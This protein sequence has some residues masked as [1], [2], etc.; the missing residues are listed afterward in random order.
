MKLKNCLT[1]TKRD[2]EQPPASKYCFISVPA[3]SKAH[4]RTA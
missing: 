3:R 2:L 4:F 1:Y